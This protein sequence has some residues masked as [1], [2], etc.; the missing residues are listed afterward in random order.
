MTNRL[1]LDVGYRY[2]DMGK[3]GKGKVHNQ[4]IYGGARYVSRL[5]RFQQK[6]RNLFGAFAFR[7]MSSHPTEQPVF[8]T[9]SIKTICQPLQHNPMI[10][11]IKKQT[12]VIHLFSQSGSLSADGTNSNNS[13]P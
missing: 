10:G 11:L 7:H 1:N 3:I 4:E 6:L 8:A 9:I 13:R 5:I 12:V 2:Y